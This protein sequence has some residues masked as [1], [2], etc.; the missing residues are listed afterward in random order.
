MPQTWKS[1]RFANGQLLF[2]CNDVYNLGT[3]VEA[4]RYTRHCS[5]PTFDLDL[6]VSYLLYEIRSALDSTQHTLPFHS[7]WNGNNYNLSSHSF[8]LNA[9]YHY[10]TTNTVVVVFDASAKQHEH[11]HEFRG[12]NP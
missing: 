11:L 4:D 9:V 2:A 1:I 5:R 3:T 7:L 12:N 6:H 10:E 8:L